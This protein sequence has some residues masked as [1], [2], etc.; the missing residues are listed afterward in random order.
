MLIIKQYFLKNSLFLIPITLGDSQCKAGCISFHILS[1]PHLYRYSYFICLF[2]IKHT[3]KYFGTCFFK[4]GG[5]D[6]KD[7]IDILTDFSVAINRAWNRVIYKEQRFISYNSGG[8]EV[9][10]LV[11]RYLSSRGLATWFGKAWPHVSSNTER[12]S[13]FIVFIKPLFP[14][15]AISTILLTLPT[16]VPTKVLSFKDHLPP[17]LEGC[18]LDLTGEM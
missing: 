7:M 9:G 10:C 1:N 4:H 2:D 3:S 17:S 6:M 12:S 15:S 13:F 16:P 18:V 14:P 8:L 11:T 5:Y